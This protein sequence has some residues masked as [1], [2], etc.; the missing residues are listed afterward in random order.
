M[1]KEKTVCNNTKALNQ[2]LIV[3]AT[4]DTSTKDVKKYTFTSGQIV[5]VFETTGTVNFQGKVPSEC[6]I[7]QQVKDKIDMI[8]KPLCIKK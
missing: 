2:I 8:N 6:D 5:N 4:V 3:N 7:E 1:S